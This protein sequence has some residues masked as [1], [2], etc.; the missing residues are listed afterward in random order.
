MVIA[1]LI[2]F[3]KTVTK[4]ESIVCCKIFDGTLKVN[5]LNSG[6]P[7]MSDFANSKDH[8]EMQH[9]AAFHQSLHCFKGKKYLQRKEYNTF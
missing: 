2:W 7:L 5:P 4:F 3:L 1:S 8:D 6:N 9:N